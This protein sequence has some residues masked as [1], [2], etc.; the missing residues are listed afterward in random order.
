ME[1]GSYVQ[2]PRVWEAIGD[3]PNADDYKEL[4]VQDWV[5]TRFKK[6][7]EYTKALR[8]KPGDD[9]K[10]L[11]SSSLRTIHTRESV[12]RFE[13]TAQGEVEPISRFFKLAPQGLCNTL[14]AGTGSERGAF[15][16]PRPIHPYQP[17]CITVREAA[18]LHSYPDRFRFHVTKWH[19]FRQVGN[20]VPPL[21]A[22]AVAMSVARALGI[23]TPR[24]N[25]EMTNGE[26]RDISLLRFNMSDA[27]HWFGVPRDVIPARQRAAD[28][29]HA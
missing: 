2:T 24:T 20:S 25:G 22:R 12:R 19:G 26:R 9:G 21:L 7:T 28:K 3:L 8:Q 29:A 27:A 14:R 10:E 11:L 17:R 23:Q 13:R 16:S 5:F 4:L 15:T 18:R 1:L 6:P